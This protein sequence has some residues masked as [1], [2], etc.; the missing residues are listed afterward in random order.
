MLDSETPPLPLK[1]G[2]R[3]LATPRTPNGLGSPIS[4]L[5]S[6]SRPEI[7]RR[8][9]VKSD[10]SILFP[11]LKLEKSNGS[12]GTPRRQ[13]ALSERS[14]PAVP[15]PT[16]RNKPGQKPDPV[17]SQLMGNKISRLN[18]RLENEH[19]ASY[20]SSKRIP[21][22]EYLKTDKQPLKLVFSP[23]LPETPPE[24]PPQVPQKSGSRLNLLAAQ[25]RNASEPLTVTSEPVVMRSPQPQ[26]AYVARILTPQ[27]SPSSVSPLPPSFV[28]PGLPPAPEGTIS[29]PQALD[30]VHL[31]C[32]QSHK[33][34]RSS[35]NTTCPVACMICRK[36]DAEKRWKCTWCCLSACAACMQVLASIPGKDLRVCLERIA[37]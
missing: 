35:R 36:K 25:S 31:D 12:T 19:E 37:G 22:P 28:F 13:E 27:P 21:T 26:K 3:Q 9:S 11:E 10:R 15:N 23:V 5:K 18:D 14:L 29:S 17:R 1:D 2:Q 30:I 33:F 20:P 4:S 32:Y 8:R 24:E 16:P 34:M 7:W 6:P